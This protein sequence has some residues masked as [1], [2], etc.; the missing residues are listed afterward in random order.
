MTLNCCLTEQSSQNQNGQ[1]ITLANYTV[2]DTDN[3]VNQSKLVV[4]V[5]DETRRKTSAKSH[6]WFWVYF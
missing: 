6:N 5:A 3:P 4:H 2:Q 1:I